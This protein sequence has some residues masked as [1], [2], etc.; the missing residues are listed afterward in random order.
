MTEQEVR[1]PRALVTG[2]GSG[3]GEAIA[4][5]L[6][7]RGYETVLAGRDERKLNALASEI[8]GEFCLCDLSL[9]A[10][11]RAL[12]EKLASGPFEILVNCAGFGLL[13]ESAALGD[14]ELEMLEVNVCA[15]QILTGAFVRSQ[16]QGRILNV[17]SAAAF[18]PAPFFAAYAA[19]KSFLYSWSRALS[20]ELRAKG[21]GITVTTLCPPALDTPFDAKAGGGPR[22]GM[23][24]AR[25]AERALKGLFAGRAL[26]LPGSAKWGKTAARL[27]PDALLVRWMHRFQLRKMQR[28][29][30]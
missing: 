18:A 11:T 26:V 7:G 23:D 24:P 20:E 9:R 10:Q 4:R 21:S 13:G 16:T 1:A 5:A 8:G 17:S 2:A 25:C 27:I 6:A 12:G 3:L 15:V 28:V 22:R 19:S 30:N 14:A 29:D